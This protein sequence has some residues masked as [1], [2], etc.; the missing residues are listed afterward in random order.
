MEGF[1]RCLAPVSVDGICMKHLKGEDAF[2]YI[3]RL[4]K[5]YHCPRCVADHN[6][7]WQSRGFQKIRIITD[8]VR[9]SYVCTF[10]QSQRNYFEL[11]NGIGCFQSY[12]F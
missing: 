10:T 7:D 12:I 9:E 8:D 4:T 5:E 2:W 1:D 11:Y 3:N 6:V